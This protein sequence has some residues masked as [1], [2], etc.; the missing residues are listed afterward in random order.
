MRN[1]AP[2]ILINSLR[3]LMFRGKVRLVSPLCPSNGHRTVSVFGTNLRLDLSNHV[4]RMIYLGCYEALN[5]Y[6]FKRILKPGM[7]VV[8]V[9]ANIGYFTYLASKSVGPQG[10]VI[11]VEPHPANFHILQETVRSNHLAQVTPVSIALGD[12]QGEG[13]ILMANQPDLVNRTASMVRDKTEQS[14]AVRVR[15]LDDCAEEWGIRTIDL[16]KIDVD[17]FETPIIRGAR[18][19]LAAGRIRNIIIEYVDYWLQESGSSAEALTALIESYGLKEQ[20]SRYRIAEQ[21]LGKSEDRHF[22]LSSA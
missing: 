21:V 8:D 18:K 22:A 13:N 17:G 7:T 11:A 3:P 10:K 4:D 20:K 1:F 19:L 12:Q 6:R 14:F 15:T 16:L 2:E 9:G 5:T